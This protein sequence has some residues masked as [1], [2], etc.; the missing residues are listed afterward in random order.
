MANLALIAFRK[1]AFAT[2]DESRQEPVTVT[3][4]VAKLTSNTVVGLDPMVH[5]F[6]VINSEIR[7][8]ILTGN[9]VSNKNVSRVCVLQ[10]CDVIG[11]Q[12]RRQKSGLKCIQS[13]WCF[14]SG[15]RIN[16]RQ[17]GQQDNSLTLP[18]LL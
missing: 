13:T 5:L 16:Y 8:T 9:A 18:L 4:E 7:Y 10:I 6:I 3:S 12:R 2:I 11:F 1:P 15:E 17:L 14:G